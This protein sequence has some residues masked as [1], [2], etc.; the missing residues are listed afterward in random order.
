MIS[1]PLQFT[2]RLPGVQ[3]SAVANQIA[4]GTTNALP[5]TIISL[6][7]HF[8][9][10]AQPGF[11]TLFF[12]RAGSRIALRWN[13]MFSPKMS[14]FLPPYSTLILPSSSRGQHFDSAADSKHHHWSP[15]NH[16]WLAR[17]TGYPPNVCWTAPAN[18]EGRVTG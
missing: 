13:I 18:D 5:V 3:A 1:L 16:R 7:F 11:F 17:H 10:S 4:P 12:A 15:V 6:R 8:F 9:P 2:F 14:S